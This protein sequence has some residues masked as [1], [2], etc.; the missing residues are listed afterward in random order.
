MVTNSLFHL[1]KGVNLSRYHQPWRFVSLFQDVYLFLVSGASKTNQS[2]LCVRS[3]PWKTFRQNGTA[4][5]TLDLYAGNYGPAIQKLQER[6]TQELLSINISLNAHSHDEVEVNVTSEIASFIL[7]NIHGVQVSDLCIGQYK[8]RVLF[9]DNRCLLLETRNSGH[10]NTSMG[11][12]RRNCLL[13]IPDRDIRDPLACCVYMFHILC[14][15]SV[16]VFRNSCL[17]ET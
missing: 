9:A 16:Q 15:R 13:F 2:A 1:P 5:R 14:G 3:R 8:F 4:L 6:T 12:S 17:L 7:G 10:S 11:H